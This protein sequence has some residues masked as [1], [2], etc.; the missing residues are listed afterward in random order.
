ML[1][2]DSKQAALDAM[3]RIEWQSDAAL[4]GDLVSRCL[5]D[6]SE[7]V[8]CSADPGFIEPRLAEINALCDGD[9]HALYQ[10]FVELETDDKWLSKARDGI[11]HGS[12]L[13]LLW[14]DRQLEISRDM[15]LAEVFN[16]ELLLGTNIVRHPEF[17]EGVRALLIDKDRNPKW[18]YSSL[19]EVPSALLD[20]F[21]ESPW[22]ENPL[23][24]L[25]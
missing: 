20:S 18:Q 14:I 24:D 21:F 2:H 4:N 8:E 9:S 10:H 19:E 7:T 13:A 17:A 6:L 23:A 15:N 25:L 5:N 22:S 12:P 11:L 1:P 16:S 3:A